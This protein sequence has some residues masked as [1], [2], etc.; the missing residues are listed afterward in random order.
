[1]GN[2]IDFCHNVVLQFL[3]NE[4]PLHL[5]A[6]RPIHLGKILIRSINLYLKLI[7]K[8]TKGESRAPPGPRTQIGLALP[9]LLLYELSMQSVKFLEKKK[10]AELLKEIRKIG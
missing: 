7:I 4:Q 10:N 6:S 9:L 2:D 8:K 5:L 1:M 3:Y